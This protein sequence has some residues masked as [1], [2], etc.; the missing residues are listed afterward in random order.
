MDF[1]LT[2]EQEMLSQMFRE[3]AAKEVARTADKADKEETLPLRLLKRAAAQGFM[4]AIAP[5]EPFGGAGLDFLTFT[6]LLEAL[7][8]ECASTALTIHVHN[9]LTLGTL[10]RRGSAAIQAN[11]IPAMI[12]GERIGAF[13]LTEAGAGSD[14]THLRT[15][16]VRVGSEYVLDG[17]K[18]WVSNAAIAGVFV[19]FA[20]TNP[21]AGPRGLSAFAVP[22]ETAGLVIGGREHTLGLSA[23]SIHRVYLNECRVPADHLLG[24]EGEGYKIALETLDYGRVGTAAIAVGLARRAVELGIKFAGERVQFGG[25][26]GNKQALQGYLAD[27]ATEVAAAEG[28]TRRAAWLAAQ[29]QPFTQQAAMAKLFASRMAA[30]VTN[31]I[32]QIHGG[33]GYIMDYPIQRYYRDARGLEIIEGTSQIQQIVIASNLFAGTNVKVR[34]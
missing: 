12:A 8:T 16:A 28:L 32:L 22:V 7:A 9:T 4:G 23:V 33:Y 3:F 10:L 15:T 14:P 27:C 31:K 34:P 1:S 24:G 26:I 13:A 18:T 11:L 17:V 6:L 19:I 25:P 21:A 20:A 30:N 2:P 29:G 5:E